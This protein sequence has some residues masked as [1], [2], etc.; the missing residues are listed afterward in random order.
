[1][2]EK[3]QLVALTGTQ[4]RAA[5]G[6]LRWSQSDLAKA[7]GISPETVKRLEAADGRLAT[8]TTTERALEAA[9]GGGGVIFIDE[10]GEGPGVRLR[11][12]K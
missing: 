12:A 8:L 3:V 7:A 4:L 10:N 6:L 1:M 5:R 11:K 9:L 2:T